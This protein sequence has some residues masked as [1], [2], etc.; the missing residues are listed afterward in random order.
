M[1]IPDQQRSMQRKKPLTSKKLPILEEEV[2]ILSVAFFVVA[3]CNLV[4]DD[5]CF[6]AKYCIHLQSMIWSSKTLITTYKTTQDNKTTHKTTINI[7]TTIKK[8]QISRCK[9]L[10]LSENYV[11]YYNIYYFGFNEMFLL[12]CPNQ[13]K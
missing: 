8:T 11:L 6:S 7:F 1:S 2:K 3:L 13:L 10:T 12:F 9:T 4:C 5:Q